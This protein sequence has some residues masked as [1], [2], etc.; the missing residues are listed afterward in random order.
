MS[1]LSGTLPKIEHFHCHKLK[2]KV[3]TEAEYA[4]VAQIYTE[5]NMTCMGDMLRWYNNSDVQ[6]FLDAINRLAEFWR[7]WK[8]DAF[9]SKSIFLNCS[10]FLNYF[11]YYS[12]VHKLTWPGP[13]TNVCE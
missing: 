4:E 3:V 9:K 1:K 13:S 2:E 8:I 5:N 7:E 10:S 12:G 6:G 11:S